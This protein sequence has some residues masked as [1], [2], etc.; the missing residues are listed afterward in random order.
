MAEF[1]EPN[2]HLVGA[3]DRRALAAWSAASTAREDVAR[4]NRIAA[5]NPDMQYAMSPTDL[6]WIFAVRVHRELQ[7]PIL[8]PE[9]REK[10]MTLST[11]LGLRRF[12][13]GVIISLVQDRARR[14][15]GL[16]EVTGALHMVPQRRAETPHA[17]GMRLT[18]AVL[19]AIA[20]TLFLIWWLTA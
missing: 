18:I 6:R 10:L 5:M 16:D 19:C 7:G 20:A 17:A 15:E 4:E 11:R 12:D 9:R 2:L 14:G 3:D 8:T 13:A 1:H